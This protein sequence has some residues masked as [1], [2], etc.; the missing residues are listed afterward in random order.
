[1][2]QGCIVI[3]EEEEGVGEMVIGV[4]GVTEEEVDMVRAVIQGQE[5]QDLWGMMV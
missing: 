3:G 4:V 2:H 1:M 5:V